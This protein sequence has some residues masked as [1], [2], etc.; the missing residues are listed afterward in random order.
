MS[1]WHTRRKQPTRSRFCNTLLEKKRSTTEDYLSA[2]EPITTFSC[3][4][5]QVYKVDDHCLASYHAKHSV[6]AG[7]E[8]LRDNSIVP[9]SQNN[10]EANK[11]RQGVFPS[12]GAQRTQVNANPF[13]RFDVN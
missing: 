1:T 3:A 13:V 6:E 10:A 4:V 11:H 7:T 9:A 5:L 2:A 8:T 12:S